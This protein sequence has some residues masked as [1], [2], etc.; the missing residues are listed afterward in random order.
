MHLKIQKERLTEQFKS[1]LKQ[2]EATQCKVYDKENELIKLM[3]L[4]ESTQMLSPTSSSNHQKGL[5][6]LNLIISL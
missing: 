4:S 6:L 1:A 2:F 3:K 5:I